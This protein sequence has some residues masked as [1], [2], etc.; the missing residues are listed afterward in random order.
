MNRAFMLLRGNKVITFNWV[1]QTF[2]YL[3]TFA[4]EK[5]VCLFAYV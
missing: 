4:P 3:L 2:V 5:T 1:L